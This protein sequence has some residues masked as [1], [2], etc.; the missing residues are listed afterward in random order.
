MKKELRIWEEE[1]EKI[2]NWREKM[3]KKGGRIRKGGM[4]KDNGREKAEIE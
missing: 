2:K 4:K 3:K 1:S